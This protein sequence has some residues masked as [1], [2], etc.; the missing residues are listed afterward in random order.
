MAQGDSGNQTGRGRD[1][2]GEAR[3]R[4]GIEHAQSEEQRQAGGEQT[5]KVCFREERNRRGSARE[6]LFLNG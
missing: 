3:G 2:R 4:A 6:Q 5:P 1:E